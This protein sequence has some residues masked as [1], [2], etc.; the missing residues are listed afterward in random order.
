M[1]LEFASYFD[2]TKIYYKLRDLNVDKT[3]YNNIDNESVLFDRVSN[4]DVTMELYSDNTI[5]NY[6]NDIIEHAKSVKIS[7]FTGDDTLLEPEQ[8]LYNKISY[9]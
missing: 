3:L 1:S 5:F 4:K 9:E 7:I 2:G 8:F 6:I